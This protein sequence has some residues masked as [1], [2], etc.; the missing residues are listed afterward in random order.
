MNGIV[1]IEGRK[2]AVQTRVL[3]QEE[4]LFA[5]AHGALKFALN[6]S[7]G[8][9]KSTLGQLQGG[10]RAGRGLVGLDGAAQAGMIQA[11]LSNLPLLHRYIAIA[12][13]ALPK[14]ECDCSRACCRRWRENPQWSEPIDWL[15]EHVLLAGLSGSISHHRL[16]RALVMRYFGMRENFVDIGKVCG[17]ERHTA[18]EFYKRVAEHFKIE[19]RKA[20]NAATRALV[21]AKIIES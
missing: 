5:S 6:Y 4:P 1:S 14:S 20:F 21:A 3:P 13:L 12:R 16:R 11:E 18:S 17:V 9:V 2:G 7:H 19:E 8:T 15:A 10:G